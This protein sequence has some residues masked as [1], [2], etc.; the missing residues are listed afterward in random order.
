L[1][2]NFS[3]GSICADF[4]TEPRSFEESELGEVSRFGPLASISISSCNMPPFVFQ[5]GISF[6]KALFFI[7]LLHCSV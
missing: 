6:C 7:F 3:F 5:S 2:L 1:A 4:V